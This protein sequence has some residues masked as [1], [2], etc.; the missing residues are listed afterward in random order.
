MVSMLHMNA[1]NYSAGIASIRLNA[2]NATRIFVVTAGFLFG[3]HVDRKHAATVV[4][5]SLTALHV[6]SLFPLILDNRFA[7]KVSSAVRHAF[8]VYLCS[9][10]QVLMFD[11]KEIMHSD[12]K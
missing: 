7:V 2:T 6:M 8:F 1:A 9:C 4:S 12:L 10:R 5:L 11:V 3:A